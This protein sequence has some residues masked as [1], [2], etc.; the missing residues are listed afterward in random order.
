MKYVGEGAK[1]EAVTVEE[2][3]RAIHVLDADIDDSAAI[4]ALLD[5][6]QEVVETATGRPF[7]PVD[8]QFTAAFGF[9]KEWWFPCRPVTEIT[10]IDLI[11]ADGV[12]QAQPLGGAR[13]GMC[14]DEPRLIL[15]DDWAGHAVEATE[16]RITATAGVA[17]NDPSALSVRRA[18]IMV[19][20]EWLQSDMDMGEQDAP[21]RAL[22]GGRRLIRQARYMRPKIYGGA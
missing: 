7:G 19:A 17:A 22:F 12:P 9:W 18:I 3:K 6:A 21:P 4:R 11:G 20:K 14:D 1:P 10:A 13:I 5:A 2:F 15:T 16:I 8:Y